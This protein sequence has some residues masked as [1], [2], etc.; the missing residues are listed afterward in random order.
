MNLCLL[1]ARSFNKKEQ[2]LKDYIVDNDIDL[3]AFT[4]T[5]LKPEDEENKMTIGD[6]CPT[7]YKFFH[8]A[9]VNKKGG[10]VGLL[11]K[12]IFNLQS[13]KT[14][15]FSSFEHIELFLTSPSSIRLVIIYRPPPSKENKLKV[16]LFLEELQI[17]LEQQLTKSGT[18]LL[19]GDFNIHM[20]DLQ[21]HDAL[22]FKNL[23]EGF[24]LTQHVSYT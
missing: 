1:N 15:K 18:L 9:K 5:W 13:Q 8:E 23:L 17:F 19:L 11:H 24:D 12:N 7:G 2:R 10:G 20:E 16:S 14:I 6:L 21:D 4:E 3:A 22:R